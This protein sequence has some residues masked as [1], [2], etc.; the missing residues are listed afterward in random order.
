MLTIKNMRDEVSICDTSVAVASN[1]GTA[2]LLLQP[3]GTPSVIEACAIAW[4]NVVDKP[5]E[6]V[7]TTVITVGEGEMVGS[8]DAL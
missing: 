3:G 2:R 1:R 8:A 5:T 6:F 4:V 7:V